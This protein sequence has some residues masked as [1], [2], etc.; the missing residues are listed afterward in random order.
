MTKE[1]IEMWRHITSK[2]TESVI[3][4]LPTK[5]SA[6]PDGFTG[7]VYQ[8]FKEELIANLTKFFQK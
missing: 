7:E 8:I 5:E 4:N 3:K 1:E 6:A 2:Q